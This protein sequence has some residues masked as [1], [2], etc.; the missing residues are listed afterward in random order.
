MNTQLVRDLSLKAKQSKK[1]LCFHESKTAALLRG[2]LYLPTPSEL[3][4]H[5]V[6]DGLSSPWPV[7]DVHVNVGISGSIMLFIL[8]AVFDFDS[9][10]SISLHVQLG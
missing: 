7:E 4:N 3:L 2:P 1:C 6:F 10:R 8:D 9:I 5:I